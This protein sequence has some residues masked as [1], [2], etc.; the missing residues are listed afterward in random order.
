MQTD[1]NK[2]HLCVTMLGKT[3][4]GKSTLINKVVGARVSAVTN[5]IQTTRVCIRGICTHG[6]T[7]IIFSDV[8]GIFEPKSKLEKYMMSVL[9]DTIKNTDMIMVLLD[10]MTFKDSFTIETT[11][12]AKKMQPSCIF[13]LN[14]IDTLSSDELFSIEKEIKEIY[15]CNGVIPISAEKGHNIDLLL[16]SLCFRAVPGNWLY[17]ENQITDLPLKFWAAEITREHLFRALNRNLPYSLAVVTSEWI[18][19]PS[20]ITIRQDIFVTEE[21]QKAIVLG[22]NGM[23]IKWVGMN[24]RKAIS[25][26]LNT[27]VDLFLK[28]KVRKFINEDI[29][30]YVNYTE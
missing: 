9:W 23:R 5:K 11:R 15:D 27:Q 16:D 30:Q 1:T 26:S 14:K 7:Q 21:G 4:A 12:E 29:V 22:H 17:E 13:V 6:N 3:N 18:D 2:K 24:S 19:N 8:P 20:K 10:P 28:V 25:E